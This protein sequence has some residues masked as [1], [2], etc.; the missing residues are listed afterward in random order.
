MIL[1]YVL[2]WPLSKLPLSI[3]HGLANGVYFLL[4]RIFGYRKKVVFDNLSKSFP[5]KSS[6]E[7]KQIASRFY[8][9]LSDLMVESIKGFSVTEKEILERVKYKNEHIIND[10]VDQ[11]RKVIYTAAHYNNWEIA[12]IATP[13]A[14][15][16]KVYAIYFPL[17]N[18]ALNEK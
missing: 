8:L 12:A 2:I 18:K 5:D 10:L 15:T 16:G 14:L 6:R 1:Y 17:K 11:G 3:L 4:Y 7:I 9:H 13:L